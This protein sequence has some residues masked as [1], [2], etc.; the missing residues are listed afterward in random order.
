M[1]R[2]IPVFL[3]LLVL[4]GSAFASQHVATSTPM[5]QQSEEVKVVIDLGKITSK[6]QISEARIQKLLDKALGSFQDELTCSVT[7]KG[8]VNV[9]IG[10]ISIEVTVSGP[11]SEIA[12]NGAAIANQILAAVKGAFEK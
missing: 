7:V 10:T 4:T 1:K 6:E 3:F 12:A 8:E 11:C 9:G 5:L 2:L